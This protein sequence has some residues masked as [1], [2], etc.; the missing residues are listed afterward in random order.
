VARAS[1]PE[2][3]A[4]LWAA[5]IGIGFAV[6]GLAVAEHARIGVSAAPFVGRYHWHVTALSV[7]APVVAGAVLLATSR[8]WHERLSWRR[9]LVAGTIANLA[10]TISLA[11]VEGRPGLSRSVDAPGEYLT[12]AR[13]I[14]GHVGGFVRHYVANA[15]QHSAATRQHPPGP[16]LL[17]WAIDRIGIHQP[18]LIG[19]VLAGLGALAV[20]LVAIAVRSLC[21]EPAGRRL[22]PLLALAPYAVWV[23]V[24]VDAVTVTIAAAAIAC[25][26]VGSEPGRSWWWAVGGGLLLGVAALF[27]Y[28]VPWLAV[29]VIAVYFVRRRALLNLVTAVAALVPLGVAR[30]AGFVWQSGFSA[31]Q[32]D[33]SDRIGVERSWPLWI[34]LDVVVL[35]VAAGPTIVPAA[36]KIRRTPGWPFVVG[37]GLAIMFAVATGLARG[38]VERSWLPFVPWLLVPAVA[39]E[40]RPDRPGIVIAAAVPLGLISLGAVASVVLEA[41]LRSPW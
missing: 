22:V 3:D 19:L 4:A 28:T 37:A 30:A 35:L 26:V 6:T 1:S 38:E 14:H 27:S 5:L 7:L 12:D 17:V 29:S 10:W 18:A 16:V 23:A 2:R 13:S 36:R 34:V 40:R 24:S 20:P 41:V 33:F 15:D 39:P 11:V 21:H 32:N 31:A 9:L 25:A 8:G